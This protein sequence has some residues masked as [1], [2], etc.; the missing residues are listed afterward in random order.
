MAAE[1]MIIDNLKSMDNTDLFKS[2]KGGL[3]PNAL[4]AR[5]IRE[6]I[7]PLKNQD[8]SISTHKMAYGQVGENRFAAFPTLFPGYENKGLQET[9]EWGDLG[10]PEGVFPEEAYLEAK[11]RDELFEFGS[12]GEAK[13]FAAGSWKPPEFR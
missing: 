5:S 10:T 8:G 12:E 4:K 11:K 3:D 6:G 7:E 1:D 9:E 2:A 13:E